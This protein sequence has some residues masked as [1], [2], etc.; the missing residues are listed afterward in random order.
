MRLKLSCLLIWHLG[1][2][3]FLHCL[4]ILHL[5][6]LP[7]KFELIKVTGMPSAAYLNKIVQVADRTNWWASTDAEPVVH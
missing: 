3:L 1:S 6:V 5:Q 7:I 4:L 2:L